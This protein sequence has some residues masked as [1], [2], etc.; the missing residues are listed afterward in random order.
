MSL[1]ALEP[2]KVSQQENIKKYTANE[3]QVEQNR[4]L[5]TDMTIFGFKPL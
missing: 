4:Y 3:T 1:C 2:R 5:T